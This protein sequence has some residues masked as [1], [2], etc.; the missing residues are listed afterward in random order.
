MNCVNG[1]ACIGCGKEYSVDQLYNCPDCGEILNF[2]YD[3]EKVRQELTK[4]T[5]KNRSQSLWRYEELLPVT[6][7]RI[8]LNE[9]ST[10]L[11]KCERFGK[12][13]GLKSFYVK[14][15]SRN[16]TGSFKDRQISVSMS[17]AVE[18]GAR[19]VATISSGNAG[20]ASA[21]YSSAPVYLVSFW[22]P[23]R[24]PHPSFLKSLHTGQKSCSFMTYSKEAFGTP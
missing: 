19:A 13:I 23:P 3:M 16:P 18:R 21:A 9:G 2:T 6:T 10:S 5:L 24:P 20:A 11:H 8:S 14:D 15:E 7:G 1:L 22:F 4:V 17:M 12:L